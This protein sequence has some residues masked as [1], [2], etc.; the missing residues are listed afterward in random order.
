MFRLCFLSVFFCF[1]Y[2]SVVEYTNLK[3]KAL[4]EKRNIKNLSARLEWKQMDLFCVGL[5]EEEK[6]NLFNRTIQDIIVAK[7]D[8][9]FV[10]FSFSIMCWIFSSLLRSVATT[11]QDLNFSVFLTWE[12]FGSTRDHILWIG[13]V[14]QLYIYLWQSCYL[15]YQ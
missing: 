2:L 14:K 6:K 10:E 5:K 3:N 7:M 11:T 9:F 1:S 8:L 4:S 13:I 12:F 15:T